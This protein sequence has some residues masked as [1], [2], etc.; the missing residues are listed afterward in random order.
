M[1]DL[2]FRFLEVSDSSGYVSGI[3][4]NMQYYPL[5]EVLA[6]GFVYGTFDAQLISRCIA[7]LTVD[8]AVLTVVSQSVAP[9]ATLKEAWYG[10][11]YGIRKFSPQET[12]AWAKSPIAAELHFPKPNIFLPTDFTIL[13]PGERQ[14]TLELPE[15]FPA[16]VLNSPVLRVWHKLDDTFFT[17][18]VIVGAPACA[19]VRNLMAGIARGH[20]GREVC[21]GAYQVRRSTRTKWPTRRSRAC[22]RTSCCAS[23][24]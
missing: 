7:Q 23:S 22:W 20:H 3:A 9:L 2:A 4:S 8:T 15:T 16:V 6:H 18:R 14:R 11:Q 10:T 17:P 21:L 1:S 5:P 24:I 19:A 12:A 13:H